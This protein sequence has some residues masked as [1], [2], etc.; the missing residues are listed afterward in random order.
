MDA[1]CL[2]GLQLAEVPD[3]ALALK[4]TFVRALK[5]ES[6]QQSGQ[7]DGASG[8]ASV[9]D[10]FDGDFVGPFIVNVGGYAFDPDCEPRSSP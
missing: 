9:V 5:G 1:A 3:D 6:G 2:T 7:F 8:F 10:V 4:G